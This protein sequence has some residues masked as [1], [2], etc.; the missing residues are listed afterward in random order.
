MSKKSY[1]I[2]FILCCIITTYYFLSKEKIVGKEIVLGQSAAL[3]GPAEKLGENMRDGANSY[4]AYINSQG[5]IYG[6]TIKLKTIDDFYEPKYT[7]EN[8]INLIKKEKVFSM[9]GY[10]G[11]PTSRAAI[12]ITNKYNIPFIAPFTG[13]EFLREPN[14]SLIINLRNSYY[15]ETQALVQ[16]LVSKYNSKRIAVFYQNDSYGNA[17]FSGVKLAVKKMGLEIAAEG[18]YRRNTLSYRNALENIRLSNPDAVISIGAYKTVA[19]FIK[20]AKKEGLK[21]I[22]FCNISFVGSNALINKLGDD[23][24]GTIISQVVPLP[25]DNSNEAVKEY[26]QIYSK[27]YPEKSF[28]FVSLEGFLAAKLVVK[29]IEKSGVDLTRKKFLE[30]FNKLNENALNG[31]HI[32]LSSKDKEALDDIY[33]TDFNNGKFRLLEKVKIKWKDFSKNIQKKH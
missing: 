16:F 23:A 22:K 1:L 8:T 29:A 27:Y 10:V 30:S 26:Q 11:T 9:F 13:A 7:I 25:W 4:F 24:Q 33:I 20:S 15:A 31:L 6:R 19:S 17:G 18:R 21:D 5:G 2:I 3:S 28:D 14:E 12:P 32:T